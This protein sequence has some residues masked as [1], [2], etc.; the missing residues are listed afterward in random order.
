M[1]LPEEVPMATKTPSTWKKLQQRSATARRA[2]LSIAR[3]VEELCSP[4]LQDATSAC[5][6]VERELQAW[7]DATRSVAERAE[8]LRQRLDSDRR[9][10]IDTIEQRLVR[11][12]GSIGHTVFGE[13]G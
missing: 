3:E 12:L 13:T 7:T 4:T 8:K 10:Q 5:T 2:L 1:P 6:F 11:T 9:E